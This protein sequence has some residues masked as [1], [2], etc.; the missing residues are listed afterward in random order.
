MQCLD[1]NRWPLMKRSHFLFLIEKPHFEWKWA[2]L[3][4]TKSSRIYLIWENGIN[5]ID[6]HQNWWIARFTEQ[7][8]M[9]DVLFC[10]D[11]KIKLDV[12]F[13]C[14]KCRRWAEVVSRPTPS[15]TTNQ[16]SIELNISANIRRM[17]TFQVNILCPFM[18]QCWLYSV[19]MDLNK[20]WLWKVEPTHD[21]ACSVRSLSAR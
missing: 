5:C 1:E 8:N 17:R 21:A 7:I 14:Q 2:R 12:F 6:G 18:L 4:A 19:E 20:Q 10:G 11:R 16:P 13:S 3:A 9:C 15:L